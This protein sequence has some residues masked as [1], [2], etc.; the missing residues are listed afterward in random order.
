MSWEAWYTLAVFGL[1]FFALVR[2]LGPP[3]AILLGAAVVLAIPGVITVEEAF[4]GF[5]N[6]GV[7]TIAAL[8]VVAGG[9]RETGALDAISHRVFG[10]IHTERG[11]LTRMALPVTAMSAFLN[12]TPI[13]AMFMP[14]VMEWCR[15]HKIP[16]SRLLMPLSYMAILGGACT[17]IGTSTN[18]VIDGLMADTAKNLRGETTL[19]GGIAIDG[20]AELSDVERTTIA[21]ALYPMS[22]FELAYVGLP[23]AFIGLLYIM[24]IAR[25]LLPDRYDA[26]ERVGEHPREF[27][28]NMRIEPGCRLINQTVEEAGLRHLPGLFLVEIDRGDEIIAPVEPTQH[29]EESDILTFSGV[30]S[31]IVDLERIPG[32]VPVAD[33]GYEQRAAERRNKMMCEAVVSA[34]SPLVGKNI[35]EADFRAT[36][37][38]AV[39]AVHRGG[40]RIGGRIGDIVLKAGDTLLLQAGPHFARANRN[41][42]DFYLVSDVEDSRPLRHD[43]AVISV[44]LLALFV[45]IMVLDLLPTVLAAFLAAGLM[46][47]TRCTY[48]SIVR[49]TIDWQTLLTIGA[50]F[51]LGAALV[52]SG[53]ANY[54]A[55]AVASTHDFWGP[56]GVLL[57]TYVMTSLFT[58]SVTN[59]AAAV[60]MFPIA[61]QIALTI[62]VDPRPFLIATTI[63]AAATFASPLGYPTN[64]MVYGPGAYRFTDFVRVGLPLNVTLTIVGTILI[65]QI[66]PF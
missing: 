36:Y 62:G 37:N 64:L 5:T 60:L 28:V 14:I 10:N 55:Q 58:E 35:R 54:L 50:A 11:A 61:L 32:L 26:M 2:N 7:L 30:V 45:V 15:K 22:L 42:A 16:A 9:L 53:I 39:I 56:Y 29:L 19:G 8:F 13:V 24:F 3:D 63:G 23:Y 38:A 49:R 21:D 20:M 51:G 43:K 44:A 48:S 65:P 27:L 59:K 46:I 33:E 66:W 40:E 4:S 1:V 57:A 18:L 47:A 34:T 6:Q 12:N 31:T 41:N 17:L 25:R 52:N